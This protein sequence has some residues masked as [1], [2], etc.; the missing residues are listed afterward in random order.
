MLLRWLP[1]AFFLFSHVWLFADTFVMF[2]FF[3]LV[4]AHALFVV[5]PQIEFGLSKTKMY[6]IMETARVSLAGKVRCD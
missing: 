2:D 6:E 3:P 1:R 5:M 4:C